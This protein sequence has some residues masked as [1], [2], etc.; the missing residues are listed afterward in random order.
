[1]SAMIDHF[2]LLVPKGMWDVSLTRILPL[3]D[4][5]SC[6]S[7]EGY[8]QFSKFRSALDNVMNLVASLAAALSNCLERRSALQV[9]LTSLQNSLKRHL[10]HL[11]KR[12]S[13]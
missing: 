13:V 9:W 7:K 3:K 4:M 8:L 2:T 12:R 10:P 5:R 1:M 6:P 11:R